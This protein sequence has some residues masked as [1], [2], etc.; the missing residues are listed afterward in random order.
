MGQHMA[1]GDSE[2]ILLASRLLQH[3]IIQNI[4]AFMELEKQ[5]LFFYSQEEQT[6]KQTIALRIK[7]LASIFSS[8]CNTGP[9]NQ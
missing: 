9:W 8:S 4:H 3:I 2:R 1:S 5:E 7:I 6:N